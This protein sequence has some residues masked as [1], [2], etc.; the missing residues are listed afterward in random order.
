MYSAPF[1]DNEILRVWTFWDLGQGEI[2]KNTNEF[3]A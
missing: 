3:F 1:V 2:G